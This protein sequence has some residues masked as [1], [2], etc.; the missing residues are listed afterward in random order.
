[1]EEKIYK[2][3][4]GKVKA[5]I[6][7]VLGSLIGF[8]ILDMFIFQPVPNGTLPLNLAGVVLLS[9]GIGVLV[10]FAH[11]DASIKIC[12]NGID[13]LVGK[14]ETHYS[15]SDFLGTN[16]IK[17]STNGIYTGTT[18]YMKFH[19][20]GT[21]GKTVQINC[22]GLK[23]AE[24]DELISYLSKNEFKQ[25]ENKEAYDDIFETEKLFEIPKDTIIR[26]N[27]RKD[28]LV[29][30]VV[31]VAA[32][33]LELFMVLAFREIS[34]LTTILVCMIVAL[35]TGVVIALR[36]KQF[37]KFRNQVPE[38]ITIDNYTL[39]VDGRTFPSE[40]T[41]KVV[42]TPVSYDTKDRVLLITTNDKTVAKYNFARLNNADPDVSYPDYPS[43]YNNIKL[44][45]LQRDISFMA[46]LS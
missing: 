33:V 11:R 28:L 38:K 27:K 42:M 5:V 4:S 30:V 46:S 23:P 8:F 31:I 19:V 14:K 7:A 25:A 39:A 10:F 40:R 16:V 15:F 17:H 36:V 45:C 41:I 1:M 24:F 9:A 43:L 37:K 20:P 18:R 22:S 12:E 3:N 35:V 32:V 13:H 21:D 34:I 29:N 26:K 6:C 2:L 44:W